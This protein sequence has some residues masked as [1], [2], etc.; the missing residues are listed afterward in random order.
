MSTPLKARILLADDHAIVRHGLRLMLDEQPDLAVV[1]EASDG[2]EA[3]ERALADELDL[4][5]LDVS[6]PRLTGI[7]VDRAQAAAAVKAELHG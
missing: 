1:S 5:I 6:M 7:Q 2:A 4:A 3:V